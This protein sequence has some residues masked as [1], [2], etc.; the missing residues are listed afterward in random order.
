MRKGATTRDPVLRGSARRQYKKDAA[1]AVASGKEMPR[2]SQYQPAQTRTPAPQPQFQPQSQPQATS[3]VGPPIDL[4]Y[5]NSISGNQLN[6][7][8]ADITQQIP[9][10]QQMLQMS[11]MPQPSANNGGQYRLSPG[12]YGTQ[13]QAMNQ[14]NQQL[15]QMGVQNAGQF[16]PQIRRG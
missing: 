3:L 8:L 6:P 9:Q 7:Q 5:F 11:Q 13:Q 14:Y 12:V 16:A 4:G 10:I 1:A 15:Q 2:Q